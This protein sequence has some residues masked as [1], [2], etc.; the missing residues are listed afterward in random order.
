MIQAKS[1]EEPSSIEEDLLTV[2]V[3]AVLV[4]G[5]QCLVDAVAKV[6]HENGL[7]E[8]WDEK[9]SVIKGHLSKWAK[10]S[11]AGNKLAQVM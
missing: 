2:D 10:C 5:T 4:E 3:S 7:T 1:I 11:S 8:L 9:H 6:S